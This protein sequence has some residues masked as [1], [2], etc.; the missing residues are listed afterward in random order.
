MRYRRSLDGVRLVD[1]HNARLIIGKDA[2]ELAEG[3]SPVT[4]HRLGKYPCFWERGRADR[5]RELTQRFTTKTDLGGEEN[6][7]HVIAIDELLELLW[8]ILPLGIVSEM[9]VSVPGRPGSSPRDSR[10]ALLRSDGTA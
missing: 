8:R 3:R 2:S 9:G 4:R 10:S 5:I 6:A 7:R 1:N